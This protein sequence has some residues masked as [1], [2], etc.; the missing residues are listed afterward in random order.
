MR[1]ET[2]ETTR[3]KACIPVL[4]PRA[5]R[6]SDRDRLLRWRQ[7]C[8]CSAAC[9]DIADRYAGPCLDPGGTNVDGRRGRTRSTRRVHRGRI[10]HMVVIGSAGGDGQC[11]R[12]CEGY[13]PRTG[14]AA[15][16]WSS[17]PW[18]DVGTISSGG[19]TI[20][21]LSQDAAGDRVRVVR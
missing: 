9:T 8:P 12:N 2:R 4:D 18:A 1:G 11:L 20:T 5:A 10:D 15:A 3:E 13:V 17:F 19:V 6:G 21:Y 14:G 16:I 7:C